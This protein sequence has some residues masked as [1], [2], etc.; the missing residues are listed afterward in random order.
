MKIRI[1]RRDVEVHCAREEFKTIAEADIRE[2][3][4]QAATRPALSGVSEELYQEAVRIAEGQEE[5][6]RRMMEEMRHMERDASDQ[7]Y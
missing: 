6:E 1:S 3:H 5:H 4:G 7:E 2:A